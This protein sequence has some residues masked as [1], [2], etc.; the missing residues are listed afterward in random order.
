MV[1][2]PHPVKPLNQVN[3]RAFC[4]FQFE[5]L[6]GVF[7]SI[8]HQTQKRQTDQT[9]M[10]KQCSVIYNTLRQDFTTLTLMTKNL[11]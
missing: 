2:I 8:K 6:P 5:V 10:T 3:I 1:C 4:V 9:D 11:H 7:L